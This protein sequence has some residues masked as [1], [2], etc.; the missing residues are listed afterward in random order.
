M[1]SPGAHF[2]S[3]LGSTKG[4]IQKIDMIQLRNIY[5]SD[6]GLSNYF[7]VTFQS[8]CIRL[9]QAFAGISLASVVTSMLEEASE[10]PVKA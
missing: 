5:F 6:N 8:L 1:G 2:G 10:M 4:L 7:L 9:L 3:K